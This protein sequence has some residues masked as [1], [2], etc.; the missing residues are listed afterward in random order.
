MKNVKITWNFLMTENFWKK[1]FLNKAII[2]IETKIIFEDKD[3]SWQEFIH[4]KNFLRQKI[5][6]PKIFMPKTFM[7]KIFMTAIS[8]TNF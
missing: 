2:N 1:I 6:M 5:Y 7:R 3:F 8:I 4:K